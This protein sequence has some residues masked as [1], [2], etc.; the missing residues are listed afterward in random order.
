MSAKS[1]FSLLA[2]KLWRWKPVGER[3]EFSCVITAGPHTSNVD[4]L[5]MMFTAW[6]R[7]MELSWMGKKSLFTT[8]VLGKVLK[9]TGGIEVDRSAPQGLVGQM[10]EQF[11]KADRLY[12]AI[13]PEGTRSHTDY[14]KSGFYRIAQGAEVPIVL[15]SID[16]RTRTV[17]IGPTLR[18]SGD[19]KAD[20]DVFRD[21]Y[22]TKTGLKHANFGPIRLR[23]EDAEPDSG[24]AAS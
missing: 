11:E 24:A 17:E 3:P 20:M 6:S 23:E 1:K 22:G 13:P 12:L 21:Y 19:L 18:P 4:Y 10:V 9:A 7:G 15:C 5:L 2:L 16:K 8:P 14:W